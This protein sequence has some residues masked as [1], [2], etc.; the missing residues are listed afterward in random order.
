MRQKM[1]QID[2]LVR[3]IKGQDNKMRGEE[4]TIQRHPVI[5][6]PETQELYNRMRQGET[7]EWLREALDG[8]SSQDTTPCPSLSYSSTNH[9]V[10]DAVNH[11]GHGGGQIEVR[12]ARFGR[13]GPLSERQKVRAAFMRKLGA[14]TECRERRVKCKHLDLSLFEATYQSEKRVPA[15]GTS[16][17]AL[18]QASDDHVRPT[19][20][21]EK[22]DDQS[23]G[24][25]SV[26]HR[27]SF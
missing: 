12:K 9:S 24:L 15:P 25:L 1:E 16:G 18:P 21:K 19:K 5:P 26:G 17:I 10:S 27:D 22:L 4:E 6:T 20:G 7:W 11:I 14:C 3:H 23:L 8:A 2:N 13:H